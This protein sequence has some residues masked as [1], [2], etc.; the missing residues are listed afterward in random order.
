M[1]RKLPPC[2]EVIID[3]ID[4]HG[5]GVGRFDNR[6]IYI[7]GALPGEKILAYPL[8]KNNRMAIAGIEAILEASPARR[9]ARE[10]HYLSCSPWQT[11][12][13]AEQVKQKLNLAHWLFRDTIDEKM[14][15]SLTLV[16]SPTLF[17]YRNK[18]E[19]S[20]RSDGIDKVSLAFH[21][22]GKYWAYYKFKDCVLAH[23]RINEC[24]SLV[25]EEINKQ[26][27]SSASL[28]NL[29][30]RYSYAEDK[31]LVSLFVKNREFKI[32]DVSNEKIAL[33]QIIYSDP[34]SPAT[35]TTEVLYKIGCDSIKEKVGGAE[36]AYYYDS[37]FQIN[38]P[39]F[40]AVIDYLKENIGSGG[41]LVDLYSGVGTIGFVLALAFEKVI[42]VEFDARAVEIAKQNA[43]LNKLDNVELFSGPT[44]KQD[45]DEI[46]AQADF[47]I[48]DPPRSGMHPRVIKKILEYAPKN[49]IYV[50]CNPAT[51]AIDFDSLSGKYEVQAWR[52]FDFYPQ[53]PHV[54]SILVLKRKK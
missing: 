48:V 8:K 54:E 14:H 43:D 40:E 52:L 26:K 4:H 30:L 39:A 22:R 18:M 3:S 6:S 27:I 38:L 45:L 46:L 17:N 11:M 13:D 34:L 20:L 44:E 5:R 25:I 19:F 21:Q 51:Q 35:K 15:K 28:K 24:A 53:T 47:L 42:S 32:F 29:V 16:E 41:T 1:S 50:S 31:C 33:W 9:S 37:F 12:D 10:E 2:F 49:F 7:Y 23:P 36:L